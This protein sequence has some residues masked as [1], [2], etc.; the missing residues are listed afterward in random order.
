MEG[1]FGLLEINCTFI[2]HIRELFDNTLLPRLRDRMIHGS[3]I[4]LERRFLVRC[5]SRFVSLILYM[6]SFIRRRVCPQL[7]NRSKEK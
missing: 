2:G 7:V 4:K 1:N 3:H 6:N 5:P